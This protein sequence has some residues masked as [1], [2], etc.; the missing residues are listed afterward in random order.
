[1]EYAVGRK[2]G[3]ERV[4]SNIVMAKVVFNKQ[5]TTSP[6]NEI[7]FREESTNVLHLKHSFLSAEASTLQKADQKT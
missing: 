7:K 3:L 6:V 4:K 1:L 2:I 5:K